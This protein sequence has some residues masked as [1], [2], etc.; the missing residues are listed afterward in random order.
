MKVYQIHEFG[1]QWEDSYDYIVGTYLY[2]D[3]AQSV[4]QKLVDVEE[5]YQKR[6]ENCQN[7][8][9]GD[10]DLNA[11]NLEDMKHACSTYCMHSQIEK[12]L[13]GFFCN[14]EESYKD[15]NHY[16]IDEIEVIE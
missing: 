7:C 8:P 5:S 14:N 9:I 12:D 6:Y 11:G 1:G 15:D 16:R 13:Y 4:M 10:L 3:R 2:K